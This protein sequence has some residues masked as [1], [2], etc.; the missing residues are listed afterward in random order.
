MVQL[1]TILAATDF[2]PDSRYAAE[3]A[4][5]LGST[6]AMKRGVLLHVL[7]QSWL[8][9]MKQL[10]SSSDKIQLEITDN[11][12]RSLAGLTEE[13]RKLSGFFLEPHVRTG[14][15]LDAIVEAA[16]DFDLLVLG[17]RGR[18]PVR[19]LALG[20]TSQ[21]ILGKTKRAVLVVKNKPLGPY[22]RVLVA[23][24]FSE[25]SRKALEYSQIIA[26]QATIFLVHVFEAL[27]EKT[28]V[29]GGA[30][31]NVIRESRVMARIETEAKLARFI[32]EVGVVDP[33]RLVKVIAQGH[34][35]SKLPEIARKK[36]ADLVIVGKHGKW[37]IEEFLLGS[38]TL[39][40]LSQSQCDVLVVK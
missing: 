29:Y 14:N 36:G 22:Q 25:H 9:S 12:T 8:D 27:L 30:S 39:H 34:A 11:A 23:V 16:P 38:V 31:E 5:L 32:K 1:Q 40:I 24:D 18:H 3:R 37:R 13:L 7:E 20:T 17:A 21:R 10:I 6:L 33:L 19:A 15:T 28:L 2:S 26:P 35:P 4:S